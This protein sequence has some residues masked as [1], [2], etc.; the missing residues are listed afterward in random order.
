[1]LW[2]KIA[3]CFPPFC[4]CLFVCGHYCVTSS[5]MC[6]HSSSLS[7]VTFEVD[8]KQLLFLHPHRSRHDRCKDCREVIAT[9]LGGICNFPFCDLGRGSVVIFRFISQHPHNLE[10]FV[11]SD[12]FQ[13]LCILDVW[14]CRWLSRCK[15]LLTAAMDQLWYFKAYAIADIGI[16]RCS[17]ITRLVAID[18][19]TWSLSEEYANIFSFN[20]SFS[21]KQ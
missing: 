3:G 15:L 10:S 13:F 21:P 12:A 5:G 20:I 4:S 16:G 11:R 19:K 14:I 6:L 2:M 17:Y 9:H 8:I 1:M 18:T 7:H